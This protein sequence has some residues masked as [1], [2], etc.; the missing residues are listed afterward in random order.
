MTQKV[1]KDD[2]MLII[3]IDLEQISDSAI[4]EIAKSSTEEETLKTIFNWG[5]EQQDKKKKESIFLSLACN[6]APEIEETLENICKQSDIFLHHVEFDKNP[7]MPTWALQE[8]VEKNSGSKI[9]F[10]N[11]NFPKDV[12]NE[13]FESHILKDRYTCAAVLNTNGEKLSKEALQMIIKEYPDKIIQKDSEKTVEPSRLKAK[14]E[15][16]LSKL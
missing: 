13:Y 9:P 2:V 15:E 14:A 5:K 11:Q 6:H 7:H 8:I 16:L 3:S 12:L 1:R 10:S 4:Y